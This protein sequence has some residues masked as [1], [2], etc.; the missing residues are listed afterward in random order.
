MIAIA[1]HAK[2]ENL[3]DLCHPKGGHGLGVLKWYS[4]E[5]TMILSQ[6]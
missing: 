5:K 6:F 4:A 1:E 2:E 3:G